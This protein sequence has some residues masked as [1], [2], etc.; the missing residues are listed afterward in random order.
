MGSK[1]IEL[2]EGILIE[3]EVP[4]DQLRQI[5]GGVTE[6]VDKTIDTIKP[7]LL[8]VCK[9]IVDVWA[10]LNKDIEVSEAQVEIALGFEGGGNVFIAKGET[11]ASL[12]LRLTFKSKS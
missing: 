5:S 11:K 10:E 8:K 6:K 1:F 12:T 3:V 7:I 4:E 2:E 9:P